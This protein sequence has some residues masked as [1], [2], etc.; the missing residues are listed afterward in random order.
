MYKA[1]R[2]E[3]ISF[4]L[5]INSSYTIVCEFSFKLV[6]SYSLSSIIRIIN[7]QVPKIVYKLR[8][9]TVVEHWAIEEIVDIITLLFGKKNC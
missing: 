8:V 9:E 7:R 6:L 2:L 4:K 3:S 1:D 5:R